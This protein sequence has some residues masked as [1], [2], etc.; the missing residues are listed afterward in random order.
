MD[1][2]GCGQ[3][4]CIGCE[5]D[6]AAGATDPELERI[7]LRAGQQLFVHGQDLQVLYAVLPSERDLSRPVTRPI[8]NNDDLRQLGRVGLICDC[9]QARI[10][11]G[12][13]VM[14]AYQ[15]GDRDGTGRDVIGFSPDS[16]SQSKRDNDI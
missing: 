9:G 8:V 16:S 15:N 1:P 10:D 7:L 11:V 14:R 2:S 5:D 12:R 3:A 6:L 13:F 4:V